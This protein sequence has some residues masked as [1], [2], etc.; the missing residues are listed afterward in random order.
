MT[1]NIGTALM[2][3]LRERALHKT[4]TWRVISY[5]YR[6]ALVTLLISTGQPLWVALLMGDAGLGLMYYVHEKGWSRLP[7]SN[8]SAPSVSSSITNTK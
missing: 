8:G 2:R 5:L 7:S 6:L 1:A 3:L 4:V